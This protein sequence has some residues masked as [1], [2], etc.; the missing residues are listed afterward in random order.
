MGKKRV[1]VSQTCRCLMKTTKN[2]Y[3]I[4]PQTPECDISGFITSECFID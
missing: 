3:Y 1:T 2:I 4:Q